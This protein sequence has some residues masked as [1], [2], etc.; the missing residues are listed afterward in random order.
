M[1]MINQKN[2]TYPDTNDSLTIQMIGE[3]EAKA[4]IN[5]GGDEEVVL[6]ILRQLIQKTPKIMIVY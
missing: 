5:W 3:I 2:Y 6:D 4:G 1:Y